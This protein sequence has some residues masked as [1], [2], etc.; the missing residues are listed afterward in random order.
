MRF[1][2]SVT[3][4][5]VVMVESGC[6]GDAATAPQATSVRTSM[7]A[8]SS[9]PSRIAYSLGNSD[10]Y[11]IAADGSAQARLTIHPAF[12]NAPSWSP[13]G[14]QIA[15]TSGRAVDP[16]EIYVMALDG[17]AQTRLTTNPALDDK[18]SW[19][20]DGRQIAF[21]SDRDGNQEIYVMAADGSTPTRLT[22]DPAA[23][24]D[25][26]WS[27][28]GARIAFVS[29]RSGTS[30]IYVMNTD[31]SGPTRLTND[32]ATDGAPSWSPDGGRIAFTSTRDGNEEIY[33]MA[34]DGSAVTRLTNDPAADR[35]P[36]WSPD[37][38][39][40]A[41]ASNRGGSFGIYVM[42]ADGSLPTLLT[43]NAAG[44]QQPSW[45]P[46]G[47]VGPP[48]RLGF[49]TQPPESVAVG[50]A[51]SP[52]LR[53]AIQDLLGVTVPGATN[54]VTVA[55]SANPGGA[56][57]SGTTTVQA[58]DG[59]ATFADLSVDHPA[60]GYTLAV[61][62]SGLGGATSRSFMVYSPRRLAFIT[63]PPTS[64]EAGVAMSPPLRVAVQDSLGNTVSSATD[65]VTLALG[66]PTTGGTLYGTTTVRAINGIATF[67]D[68]RVDRPGSYTLAATAPEILGA[69]SAAFT[70]HVTFVSM[71][72]AYG[73]TCAIAVS[74]AAYC[75][76]RN[77]WGQLGDETT[78]GRT[79]PVPVP[80]SGGLRFAAIS[81]A[82][83]H[84]CGLST[85]GT[86]YCWGAN[87]Y[88]QLGDGTTAQ[89]TSPTPVSGQLR[90]VTIDAGHLHTCGLTESG[91]AYCWGFNGNG[92]L[93][94]G[95]TTT[96]TS[97]VPV[98]GGHTFAVVSAGSFQTCGVTPEG[99]V[100]CW[101]VDIGG[102]TPDGSVVNHTSP[103][104]VLGLVNVAT[105]SAGAFHDCAVTT[106]G[107]GYCWG[108][109]ESG[110]LGDG[111]GILYRPV[112]LPVS[113]L[114]S[115]TTVIAGYD[116]TCGVTTDDTAYCW[117]RNAN[118][119]LGDGSQVDRA[120][121]TPVAGGL[122]FTQVS[123]GLG[124]H[125]CGLTESNVAYC[126]GFNGNGQ[127]G[128]GTTTS[129]LTPVPVQGQA[130]PA[131][132]GIARKTPSPP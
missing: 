102:Q 31:G 78:T 52:A 70:I 119:Q 16:G 68:L 27:P 72:T 92:Q 106:A 3:L 123:A 46:A 96:R 25:P 36:T 5:A 109:N 45:S 97:P 2:L 127:I 21:M 41:F 14:R 54:A 71:S 131:G 39:Q 24:A 37:G 75:W 40:I 12:D 112:P 113:G 115:F 62:S 47:V 58:V 13:D 8:A 18:S 85:G 38:Q 120:S 7:Q 129:S 124:G 88:G 108:N 55:L 91:A 66:P 86:V 76:G 84:T 93:G 60:S 128:D 114:L 50:A 94:D 100:F 53:V 121:P 67:S 83:G 73:H 81:A 105:V 74:G 61:T 11:V 79:S 10:I 9:G 22:N 20:P 104:Q 30:Q 33:V 82:W 64:I 122:H 126:W 87:D 51:M 34:A 95:T 103:V 44:A 4:C 6:Q 49:A 35:D 77:F 32:G 56:T 130:A 23:D 57:L 1:L 15:F 42:G 43:T 111:G 29:N 125:T 80:V 63:Q 19:S 69:T 132:A 89:R 48:S 59:I 116:Y 65:S 101:G 17:S 117:G 98:T 90:F 99:M 110:Q 118:G 28:D 26:S 107:T